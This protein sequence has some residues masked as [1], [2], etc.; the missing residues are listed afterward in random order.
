M[1]VGKEPTGGEG[2]RGRAGQAGGKRGTPSPRE[3]P[4][5]PFPL[6]PFPPLR[7]RLFLRWPRPRYGFTPYPV[8]EH[9]RQKAQ[10]FWGL[11]RT[12]I[13]CSR[14]S[15]PSSQLGQWARERGEG[16]NSQNFP[17]V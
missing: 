9:G 7:P 3:G 11:Y 15:V 8:V 17:G 1:V 16:V 10:G 2:V 6:S 12:R 13:F 14:L 4:R 5:P